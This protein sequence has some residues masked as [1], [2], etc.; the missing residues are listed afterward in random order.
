MPKIRKPARGPTAAGRKN[1]CSGITRHGDRCRN[2]APPGSDTRRYHEPHDPE[3][4]SRT[5]W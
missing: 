3:P 4:T 5:A 2:P 1:R